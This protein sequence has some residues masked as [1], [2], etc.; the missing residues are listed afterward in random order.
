[1]KE[2][3]TYAKEWLNT[4]VYVFGFMQIAFILRQFLPHSGGN[5]GLH[6]Y[7]II[8]SLIAALVFSVSHFVI[9][10][11]LFDLRIPVNKRII[12]CGIPCALV[13]SR[14]AYNLGLQDFIP[15][16]ANTAV[17][18]VV[19]VLSYL[20]SLGI[21]MGIFFIIEIKLKKQSKRY[22]AA[23]ERYKNTPNSDLPK[24]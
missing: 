18:S 15:R 6:W 13:G 19:W 3:R 5:V 12:Y 22:N 8:D 11:D 7:E 4:F 9:H 1:M 17:A 23:L 10:S 2:K 24:W 21:Y 14:L 20:V 16:S